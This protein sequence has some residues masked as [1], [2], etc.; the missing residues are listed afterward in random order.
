MGRLFGTDGV[1]GVVN[2]ELTPELAL[3]LGRAIGA[4]L[5]SGSRVLM[6]RD[7]RAGGDMISRA[8]SAGLQ[9]EGVKVYNAGLV[10][11][12]ALQLA[13][14]DHGFDFGVIVTASHNPPEYNGIKIVY[15]DGIEA[16][17]EVEREIE[18]IY[19]N[20][21]FSEAPWRSLAGGEEEYPGVVDYYVE[22]VVENA[23]T[24]ATAVRQA[25][26]SVVVDCANSVSSM[27]TPLVLSRLGARV[28]TVNCN[29][30]PLFS[31]RLPEPV[32]EN[33][34]VLSKTVK[35]TGALLGIAHD[36]DGDRAM[37]ADEAGRVQ[38][39]DRTGTLLALWLADLVDLPR[40]VYTVVSASMV[41]E[42][43]LRAHGIEVEWT[44]IGSLYISRKL[45]EH[46]GLA[47]F[48]DNGGYIHPPHQLVRDGAMTAALLY[49]MAVDNG[50][51]KAL[52]DGLPRYESIKTKV[53]MSRE[54]A[55]CAVKKAR[56][57][58]EAQGYRIIDVDGV[59][60]M[61][62]RGWVLVRPSGTE[63]LLRVMVEA[64]TR[65]EAHRLIDQVKPAIEECRGAVR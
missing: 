35:S 54:E 31:G 47:G 12:P 28:Y 29:L 32:P 30:D 5:G 15:N 63:P 24:L 14:R 40:R 26:A 57:L 43:V 19:F 50:G 36:G 38:W 64:K 25:R 44:P 6:G 65:E 9:A 23:Q 59:K 4:Y 11:T 37:V 3:R 52:F 33:L 18:E 7:V 20:G 13:V 2:R 41:V 34:G 27:A 49:L 17:R 61:S 60:A 45:A 56:S 58:L 21:R 8:L 46:G 39:G 16:P 1:R 53:P 55:E 62:D 22:R 42:E 10:P 51:L 48:E